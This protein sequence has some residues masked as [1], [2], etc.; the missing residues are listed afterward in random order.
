MIGQ[1][2]I[3]VRFQD[4]IDQELYIFNRPQSVKPAKKNAVPQNTLSTKTPSWDNIPLAICVFVDMLG[5][6]KMSSELR[7]K[8]FAR[9]YLF[10]VET[11]LRL[12]DK[13]NPAHIN[14]H[15]DG[16]FAI[17]NKDQF[18]TSLAAA[19][20]FKTFSDEVYTPIVSKTLG[21]K[22]GSHIGIDQ[23]TVILGRVP[24]KEHQSNIRLNEI[25][26]GTPVN[27]A[28][29]L[30]ALSK[31]NEILVSD[32]YYKRI[33]NGYS[34]FLCNCYKDK[35]IWNQKDFSSNKSFDF[36]IAYGN[37]MSWCKDHGADSCGTLLASDKA[38]G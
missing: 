25:W 35:Q 15:G 21:K 8:T 11:A 36:N 7:N 12:F 31:N 5:S 1:K 37:K 10:Y 20:T 32:R 34:S 6:T 28:A 26:A 18:H 22:T 33:K 4:I 38:K 3:P 24:L 17:F 30:A 27:M 14:V 9:T 29:K 19:I 13:F 16:V 23:G 2:Q